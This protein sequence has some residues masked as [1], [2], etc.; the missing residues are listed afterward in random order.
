MDAE[1]AHLRNIKQSHGVGKRNVQVNITKIL[2]GGHVGKRGFAKTVGNYLS[3]DI[4]GHLLTNCNVT[5]A[6]G[7]RKAS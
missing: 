5:R 3:F 6:H 7:G 1:E 4:Q 2:K